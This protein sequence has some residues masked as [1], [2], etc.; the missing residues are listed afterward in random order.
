MP[1]WHLCDRGLSTQLSYH[2]IDRHSVQGNLKKFFFPD[3]T[4]VPCAG[5]LA[6]ELEPGFSGAEDQDMELS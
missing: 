5:T 6:S 2:I 4:I 3:R 1:P